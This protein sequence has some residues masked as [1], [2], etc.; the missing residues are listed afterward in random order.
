MVN[1][2]TSSLEL[3]I[4][5]ANVVVMGIPVVISNLFIIFLQVLKMKD[6]NMLIF[7]TR[8]K[9][10]IC[11]ISIGNGYLFLFQIFS[12]LNQN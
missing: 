1:G 11:T 4:V 6:Y 2:T 3:L 9:S 7:L 10:L 8:S 12:Q 5:T